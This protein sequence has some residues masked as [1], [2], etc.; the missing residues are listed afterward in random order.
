[1]TGKVKDSSEV[2]HLYRNPLVSGAWNIFY[3]S[4]HMKHKYL[5][6]SDNMNES[7]ALI[8]I[9]NL[10]LYSWHVCCNSC[11]R[12]VKKCKSSINPLFL[13]FHTWTMFMCLK[14]LWNRVLKEL[15]KYHGNISLDHGLKVL[16]PPPQ[17]LWL[18]GNQL[19]VCWNDLD[20]EVFSCVFFCQ[21]TQ[22]FMG[23]QTD[24]TLIAH[25]RN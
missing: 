20:E 6:Y 12:D 13:T 1:M 4:K 3:W 14:S 5:R 2:L 21:C 10:C 9:Y 18:F 11:G 24:S 16:V 7:H 19:Y 8:V 17:N 15:C 23:Y 22:C 25:L